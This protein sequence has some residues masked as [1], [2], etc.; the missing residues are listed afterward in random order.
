MVSHGWAVT[1]EDLESLRA[2]LGAHEFPINKLALV[3]K[4]GPDNLPKHR[5]VWDLWRSMV[6]G[7]VRQ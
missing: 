2:Q 4:V 5:I 1:C 7:L 6:N 3:S